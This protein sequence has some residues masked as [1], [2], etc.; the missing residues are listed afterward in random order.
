M[1]KLLQITLG[2]IGVIVSDSLFAETPEFVPHAPS[3]CRG[4]QHMEVGKTITLKYC[5][6]HDEHQAHEGPRCKHANSCNPDVGTVYHDEFIFSRDEANKI[7]VK[8]NPQS[9]PALPKLS[10]CSEKE[11]YVDTMIVKPSVSRAY[12]AT[13]NTPD[14]M[15]TGFFGSN[16]HQCES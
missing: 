16:W 3:W 15:C 4:V 2:L 14:E 11:S 5:F 1:N 6:M 13:V 7:S 10:C 8:I 9:G 12:D